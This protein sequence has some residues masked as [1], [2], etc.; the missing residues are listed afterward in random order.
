MKTLV[1]GGAG[2]IGS[3]LIDQLLEKGHEVVC[4]DNLSLGTKENIAHL[5]NNEAFNF[6][7]M[8]ICNAK[9]LEKIIV[10]EQIEYINQ[11]EIGAGNTY[12]ICA[13]TKDKIDAELLQN[14]H[15]KMKNTPYQANRVIVFVKSIFNYLIKKKGYTG[16]NPANAVELYNEKAKNI[17][18]YL[19]KNR[20]EAFFL[21]L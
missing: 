15:I 4:I 2:F 8:D 20:A 16:L 21:I 7:E 12:E 13:R 17:I 1:A 14:L 9:E 3:H 11:I 5:E 19:I 18:D 10:E 6:Y